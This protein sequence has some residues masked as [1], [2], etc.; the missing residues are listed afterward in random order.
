MLISVAGDVHLVYWYNYHMKNDTY[1]LIMCERQHYMFALTPIRNPL[2]PCT[3]Q[4]AMNIPSRA[5]A[6][7][8]ELTKFEINNCQTYVPYNG[9]HLVPMM[10]LFNIKTDGTHKARLVGRGDLMKAYVLI[11]T[12][13][14]V[15]TLAH[16]L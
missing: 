16:A 15:A 2:C 14:I 4:Q 10:W 9:Q 6:I 12:Q 13:F 1:P 11:L 3:Y 8:K 7:D 5:A